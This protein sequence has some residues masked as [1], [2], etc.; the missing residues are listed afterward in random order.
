MFDAQLAYHYLPRVFYLRAE[1]VCKSYTCVEIEKHILVAT[2]CFHGL[3]RLLK[4]YLLPRK[5]KL[6]LY[7][8]LIRPV[9]TYTSQTWVLAEKMKLEFA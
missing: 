9:C 7:K 6:L 8:V 4:S 2:K 3:Q 1:I 5:T